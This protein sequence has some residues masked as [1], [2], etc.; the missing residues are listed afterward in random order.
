MVDKPANEAPFR[1]IDDVEFGDTI[2]A[3][4]PARER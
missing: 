2:V 1:V 3:G 4:I